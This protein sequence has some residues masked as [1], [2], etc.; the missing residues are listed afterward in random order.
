MSLDKLNKIKPKIPRPRNSDNSFLKRG[1]S[2][3]V[4]SNSARSKGSSNKSLF[5]KSERNSDSGNKPKH[6]EQSQ[7]VISQIDESVVVAKVIERLE[8]Y[9]NQN[10]ANKDEFEYLR[11]NAAFH[12]DIVDLKYN[13][14]LLRNEV[15]MLNN[16]FSQLNESVNQNFQEVRFDHNGLKEHMRNKAEKA[17]LIE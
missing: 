6:P 10:Y 17:A 16:L 4:I 7:I 15:K 11:N 12:D 13:F 5:K 3:D 8:V 9:L 2:Q 1:V 14:D